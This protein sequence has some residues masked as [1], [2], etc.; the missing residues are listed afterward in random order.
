MPSRFRPRL[1]RLDDR[2]TPAGFDVSAP[3]T[4]VTTAA[5]SDGKVVVVG[6]VPGGHTGVEGD[7]QSDLGITRVTADGA[8]DPTFNGGRVLRVRVRPTDQTYPVGVAV[9]P[10]GKVTVLAQT[11]ET[12]NMPTVGGVALTVVVRVNP[13]GTPDAGFGC[14]GTRVF[15]LEESPG[16]EERPTA[17]AVG[18]DGSTVV[19]GSQTSMESDFLAVRL[20]PAGGFDPAFDGDGRAQIAVPVNGQRVAMPNDVAVLP[21]GRVVIGGTAS[22]SALGVYDATG[23][24]SDPR[25]RVAV[26]RLTPGGAPDAGFD[27]DGVA[28]VGALPA[29]DTTSGLN[30]MAVLPD[31]RVAVVASGG[32]LSPVGVYTAHLLMLTADG[33]LDPA[34][35]GD[36][37]ADLPAADGWYDA[38]PAEVAACPD[39]SLVVAG[40]ERR[41]RADPSE[42]RAFVT[43][44]L[45]DGR[46][47]P[48]FTRLT[49]SPASPWYDSIPRVAARPDG[50]A[51]LVIPSVGTAG[52]VGAVSA[53]GQ[54]FLPFTLP[55]DAGP[56]VGCGVDESP[57]PSPRQ[58]APEPVYDFPWAV[59]VAQPSLVVPP[60]VPVEDTAPRRETLAPPLPT[61]DAPTATPVAARVVTDGPR[62]SVVSR[63][64]GQVLLPAF[65][66]FEASYTGTLNAVLAD[67]DGDGVPELVVAPESG[68]GPVVAV[69]RTDGV[70][71]ARFYGIDD[72]TFRGGA[73]VAAGDLD[74]DGAADLVVTAG[75]GGGPRVAVFDGR[76]LAGTRRKLVGD[77]F[78]FEEGQ[79]GGATVAAGDVTGDGWADLTFGAGQGGGPRVRVLDGSSLMTAKLRVVA[80]Y[81]A[82]DPAARDGVTV[83]RPRVGSVTTTTAGRSQAW[84]V[85]AGEEPVVF[86]GAVVEPAAVG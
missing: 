18:P 35:D 77:F 84:A 81:F 40:R 9:G 25:S 12:L 69:F 3:F 86:N 82:G 67:L 1:D 56:P 48:S 14:Q 43:A 49:K 41:L 59:P 8:T 75:P 30:D 78:A 26:V 5:Q 4:P 64:D 65:A 47:D 29:A 57:D 31:G 46:P 15:T 85:R 39:G 73:R 34:F 7:R 68:G 20:T 54:T 62:V 60:S 6:T 44:L 10:D 13:D 21:D 53:D 32:P 55:A 58:V 19:V 80:D 63:A 38:R 42:S 74:G 28:L 33:A 70:E 45:A 2:L 51:V 50:S 76:Q 36:G 17:L 37:R 16:F 23:R 79:R 66:P 83:G 27:G 52:E 11:R 72:V 24:Y 71:L 61:P 22:E